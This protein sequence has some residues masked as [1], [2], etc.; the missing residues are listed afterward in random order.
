[1]PKANEVLIAVKACSV[2]FPDALIIE[3]K[4]QIRPPRP[5]APGAEVAGVIEAVGA[6]VTSA[7]PGD[8]VIAMPGYGGSRRTPAI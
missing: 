1:M 8:R 7:K 2:N 3:D 4:Y 6:E 5:F